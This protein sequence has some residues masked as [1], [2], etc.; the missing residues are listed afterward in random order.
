M[1]GCTERQRVEAGNRPRAHGEDIAQYSADTGRRALIRLDVAR[2]V[3]ALHL[4]HVGEAVTDIDDA[5][6]LARSPGMTH[7]PSGRQRAQMHLG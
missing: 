6:I 5:G 2:V 7:G 4:E 3:V 1:R